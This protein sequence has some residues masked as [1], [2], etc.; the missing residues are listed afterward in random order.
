MSYFSLVCPDT[1]EMNRPS[2]TEGIAKRSGV[3]KVQLQNSEDLF[4]GFRTV[5]HGVSRFHV[6]FRFSPIEVAARVGHD[7]IRGASHI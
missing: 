2:Y 1:A 5:G 7:P 6:K 4:F 3:A